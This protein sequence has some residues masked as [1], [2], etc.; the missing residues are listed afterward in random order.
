MDYRTQRIRFTFQLNFILLPIFV[1]KYHGVCMFIRNLW[2]LV[3]IMSLLYFCYLG[4]EF[5]TLVSYCFAYKLNFQSDIRLT[6]AV[7]C[8]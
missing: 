1:G 2:C 8:Y 6:Y 5:E 3:D 7:G 4:I